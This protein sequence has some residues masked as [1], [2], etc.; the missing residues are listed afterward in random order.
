VKESPI[1]KSKSFPGEEQRIFDQSS[2]QEKGGSDQKWR[3]EK[4]KGIWMYN[5]PDRK[6]KRPTPFTSL[7]PSLFI[8][9]YCFPH[10]RRN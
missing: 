6:K 2:K 10:F 5:E 3:R 1:Q 7:M 4:G 8:F 9:P